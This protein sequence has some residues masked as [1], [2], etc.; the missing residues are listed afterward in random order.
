MSTLTRKGILFG[1]RISRN[2]RDLKGK[3]DV[4]QKRFWRHGTSEVDIYHFKFDENPE[5]EICSHFG[6]GRK[7]SLREK[8]FGNKCINHSIDYE[9]RKT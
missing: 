9:T 7:L 8:L 4:K 6:C 1:S 2:V 3:V 5:P